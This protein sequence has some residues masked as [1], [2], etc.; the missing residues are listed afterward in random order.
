MD[1]SE[2]AALWQANAETWTRHV[3]LGYDVYRDALNTPAF[4]EIL[5][6]ID[7]LSGLDIGCGEGANTR[8]LARRGARMTAVD[9]ATTF[10]HFAQEA[11]TADPLGIRYQVADGMA[12]PSRMD[13]STLSP[14]SCRSWTCPTRDWRFKK[15]P[16]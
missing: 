2:V 4:L 3:R 12:L 16:A 10:I 9:I 8:Q 6:P 13:P 14:H 7:G 5:P 15:R 11:E 1:P